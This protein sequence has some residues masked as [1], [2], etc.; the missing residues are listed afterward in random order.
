MKTNQDCSLLFCT[1]MML[2]TACTPDSAGDS[3]GS[4]ASSGAAAQSSSTEANGSAAVQDSSS[5]PAGSLTGSSA[6]TSLANNSSAPG[7]LNCDDYNTYSC[8]TDDPCNWQLDGFCDDACN[9]LA[10]NPFD[11]SEDCRNNP[12]EECGIST[13]ACRTDDPCNLAGDGYCQGE[14]CAV[15]TPAGFEVFDDSEDCASL[16]P[17]GPCTDRCEDNVLRYCEALPN[18]GG[19]QQ[20]ESDCGSDGETCFLYNSM[21]GHRCG[22]PEGGNCWTGRYTSTCMRPDNVCEET[23][24][25]GTCTG[26]YEPCTFYDEVLSGNGLWGSCIDGKYYDQ[27]TDTGTFDD[28]PGRRRVHD[29]EADGSTCTPLGCAKLSG[30]PCVQFWHVCGADGLEYCPSEGVCP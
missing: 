14:N 22:V 11:D 2:A 12:P 9:D 30:Q 7:Q 15:A 6:A 21:W 24:T 28:E 25:G 26:G 20:R 23:S 13:Y 5:A 10:S 16:P 29:C 1:L 3:G 17:P 4:N 19:Y 8:R 27:C 18:G